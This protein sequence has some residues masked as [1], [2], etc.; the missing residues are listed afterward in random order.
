MHVR[1]ITVRGAS[2]FDETVDFIRE[3]ILP[4]LRQQKGFS[5]INLSGDRAAGVFTVL[6][7]WETEAS[8]DASE[9]LSEKARNE[10][11][12]ILGGE[13]TVDR[14]EQVL[15]E[16]GSTPPAPGDKLHIRPIKM[17]PAKVD[18]NLQFFKQTVLPDI[19]AT[20]GFRGVRQLINRQSGDGRVGTVWADAASLET[21]LKKAEERRPLGASRGVEFGQDEVLDVLFRGE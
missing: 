5:S 12:G 11:L 3:T 16:I 7:V 1:L 19:K 21:A 4:E 14:Y 17:D 15:W 18:E 2:R 20:P 8:R 13:L 6:S 10:A 9:G